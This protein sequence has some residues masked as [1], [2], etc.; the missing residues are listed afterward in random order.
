MSTD[1]DRDGGMTDGGMKGLGLTFADDSEANSMA[2]RVGLALFL[3]ASLSVS[4][5]LGSGAL[6][7][8]PHICCDI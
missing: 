7:N 3:P 2:L 8:E 5:S 4:G 1:M 6:G